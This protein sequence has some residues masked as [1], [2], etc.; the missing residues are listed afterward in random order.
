M[1]YTLL[2]RLSQYTYS[3][4]TPTSGWELRIPKESTIV[5][6]CKAP[7]GFK[8]SHAELW[9][10]ASMVPFLFLAIFVLLLW[11][12]YLW[13]VTAYLFC[14]AGFCK[15]SSDLITDCAV[16]KGEVMQVSWYTWQ[17]FAGWGIQIQ[18]KIQTVLANTDY[19]LAFST[20]MTVFP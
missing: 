16:I 14:L 3:E 5:K 2:T 20:K 11:Y 6:V 12:S 13:Q 7:S 1:F 19:A 15:L 9:N 8:W 17:V 4:I 10:H 18:H